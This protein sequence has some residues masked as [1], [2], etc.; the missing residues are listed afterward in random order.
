[1]SNTVVL[2][3][4]FVVVSLFPAAP[5]AAYLVS[6]RFAAEIPELTERAEAKSKPVMAKAR[7]LQAWLLADHRTMVTLLTFT[8]EMLLAARGVG[9]WAGW[10]R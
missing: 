7:L 5:L 3:V 2:V 9:L 10:N 6:P 4:L 8:A 1:M